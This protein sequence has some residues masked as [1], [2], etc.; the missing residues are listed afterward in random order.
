MPKLT[1][2]KERLAAFYAFVNERHL[3]WRRRFIEKRPWPWT[4]DPIMQKYK[5][6]N[7]YRE[8]DRGTMYYYEHILLPNY[9]N[10]ENLLFQTVLYRFFNKPAVFQAIGVADV[11]A[12]LKKYAARLHKLKLDMP[13]FSPAYRVAC[14][15]PTGAKK[16]DVVMDVLRWVKANMEQLQDGAVRTSDPKEAFNTLQSIP[17]VGPF[18]AYELY[19][20]LALHGEIDYNLDEFVNVGPGAKPALMQIFTGL[21][22]VDYMQAIESLRDGLPEGHSCRGAFTFE[23]YTRMMEITWNARNAEHSLCEF[24][25]YT[26]ALAAGKRTGPKYNPS[27]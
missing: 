26:N 23:P 19:C 10:P 15:S 21:A 20:D 14:N 7:V 18:L 8:L 1:P 16:I 25:K 4:D 22:E 13:V 9:W 3:I 5:F 27:K 17:F 12:N 11:H 6:T 2:D 24:R